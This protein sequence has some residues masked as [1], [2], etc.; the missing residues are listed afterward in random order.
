MRR[1][2]F[3]F[4]F[5]LSGITT[6]TALAQSASISMTVDR[7]ELSVGE[8]LQ[9]QVRADVT[10]GGADDLILPD[11]AAFHI[12]SRRV[13]R[14]MQFSFGFGSQRQTVRSSVVYDLVLQ[15]TEAGTFELRP[16]T[17]TLG[18]QTFRS[19]PVTIAVKESLGGTLPPR[20]AEPP[21]GNLDGAEFDPQAFVRT[22]VDQDDVFVGEQVTVTVYL[23]V[24]GNLRSAPQVTRAPSTDGFWVHDL[25]PVQRSLSTQHQTVN[26]TPF[27][28]YVI[29]RFAAFPL[30]A[31]TLT[32]GAPTVSLETG[33]VFDLFNRAGGGALRR[34]GV[35]TQLSVRPLPSDGRPARS[36]V[37][38]GD[39]TVEA[40]LDRNQVATGDAVT[41]RAK[42]E[43]VGNPQ[44]LDL[45]APT[46]DGLRILAPE[47]DEAVRSPSDLVQGS[48][49][50]RWLIIP[51]RPGTFRVGPLRLATFDPSTSRYEVLATPPLRL[52]AAGQPLASDPGN[53]EDHSSAAPREEALDLSPIRRRS[54]LMPHRLPLSSNPGFLVALAAPPVVF[55]G[56]FV[57]R[58][59][60]RR[61]QR[62]PTR[63]TDGKHRLRSARQHAESGNLD[64]FYGE[65]RRALVEGLETRLG[66][67]IGGL[68]YPE[69]RDYLSV[70]GMDSDMVSRLVDELEG[71]EFARFSAEGS[72]DREVTRCADSTAA[73]LDS[74][75]EFTPR[76]EPEG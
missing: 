57:T 53:T 14:P 30:R 41:L 50:W 51:E 58:S 44:E 54:D 17:L 33:S 46:V 64:L 73:L 29:R 63:K 60:R 47:I 52:E 25:L 1:A 3:G 76:P 18:A 68:T 7:T 67:K 27:D 23:Y 6:S 5:A 12:V 56:L 62:R 72:T 61:R 15:A 48:R 16:A 9:M 35:A 26:G 19:E 11:L 71:M 43:G 8:Q 2:A 55:A 69:L 38:V 75:Q 13:A 66:S 32:V 74:L 36:S 21:T 40:T 59:L 24:R 28:V 10:G 34:E 42:V 31:G 70:K 37:A 22:V 49:T 4:V 45:K 20:P 39:W 65:A